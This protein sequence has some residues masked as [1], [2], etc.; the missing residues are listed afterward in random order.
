MN[1]RDEVRLVIG[2]PTAGM[3]RIDFAY[4]LAG[5]ISFL[6]SNC[7]PSRP[8]CKMQVSIDIA[9]S[10]VIHGNRETI[11]SRAIEQNKTHLLF[12]DDDMSFDPTIIDVLFSRRHPVV[13]TNY[14]IKTVE[15]DQF[16][17][18]GLNGDRV[19]TTEGAHG[20]VPITYSGF[21]VSLFEVD[22]F[23]NVPQ[24]WF[25]PEWVPEAKGYT[26]EDKPCFERIRKAGYK[27]YL[28]H[29]A[30]KMVTHVGGSHWSWKEYKND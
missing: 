27:V 15:K 25:Q 12:L 10:S 9:A 20:L 22:V 11:V 24:P 30:S 8:E 21:G 19:A 23:K 28:D 14:L 29:D 17:A 2:I 6:A 16:V 4:S 1:E 26:T 13:V 3:V 5:L 18:V 7:I